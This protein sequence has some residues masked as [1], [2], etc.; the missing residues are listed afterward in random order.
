MT[1]LEKVLS[2]ENEEDKTKINFPNIGKE[3]SHPSLSKVVATVL[4]DIDYRRPNESLNLLP[5][6]S[7]IDQNSMNLTKISFDSIKLQ[8]TETLA[9]LFLADRLKMYIKTAEG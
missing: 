1:R 3:I 9:Y 5:P 8:A 4:K 6:D 7:H 2:F